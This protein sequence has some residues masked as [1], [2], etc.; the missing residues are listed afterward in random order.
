MLALIASTTIGL[1]FLTQAVSAG[2]TQAPPAGNPAFP[3]GP[4]GPQGPQGGPG[5]GGYQGYT[6]NTGAPGNQGLYGIGYCN[7]NSGEWV[8]HGWDGGCASSIGA[9]FY[10]NGYRLYAIYAYNDGACGSSPIYPASP[11]IY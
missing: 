3:A 1:L 10:C 7:W 8:S 2:P 9:R 5:P 11:F 4:Q 6:G